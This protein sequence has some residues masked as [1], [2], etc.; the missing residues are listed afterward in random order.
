MKGR[1]MKKSSRA[2]YGLAELGDV[3]GAHSISVRHGTYTCRRGFFCTG[4]FTSK[5][6]ANFILRN[7]KDVGLVGLIVDHG[8]KWTRFIGGA[9]LA[10]QS[11]WWV[12][13]RITGERL[14]VK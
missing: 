8:E 1:T 14:P 10:R 5:K 13:F 6:Y 11:H 9:P 4:G 7:L 3:T 12:K 2:N